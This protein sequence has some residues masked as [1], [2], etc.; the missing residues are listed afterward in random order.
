MI[1]YLIKPIS[2][3]FKKMFK[4]KKRSVQKTITNVIGNVSITPNQLKD[5]CIKINQCLALIYKY[6][7]SLDKNINIVIAPLR[8]FDGELLR[9]LY[10]HLLADVMRQLE[11]NPSN[12][13]KVLRSLSKKRAIK[14]GKTCVI[15]GSLATCVTLNFFSLGLFGY[16]YQ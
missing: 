12:K 5:L 3:Y 13:T 6:R 1:F 9:E 7:A 2:I 14:A 11:A 16:L 10:Q 4:F 15:V 8:D